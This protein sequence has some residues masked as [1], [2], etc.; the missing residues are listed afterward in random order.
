LVIIWRSW[1]QPCSSLFWLQFLSW[2]HWITCTPTKTTKQATKLLTHVGNTSRQH[3][4]HWDQ[5][6][7]GNCFFTSGRTSS[8]T[9]PLKLFTTNTPIQPLGH[10]QI[11][12]HLWKGLEECDPLKVFEKWGCE[13][14]MEEVPLTSWKVRKITFLPYPPHPYGI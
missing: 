5:Q 8:Q 13:N 12:A 4:K 14:F 3:E 1:V 10:F 11:W 9:H 2:W 6:E 7:K